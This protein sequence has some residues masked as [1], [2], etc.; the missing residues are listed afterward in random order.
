MPNK[1]LPNA[2]HG[3]T[4]RMMKSHLENLCGY[5]R[6]LRENTVTG[7]LFNSPGHS[8][9]ERRIIALEQSK[10]KNP[11]YKNKGRHTILIYLTHI[12]KASTDK[13]KRRGRGG[14][15]ISVLYY[16]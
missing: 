10:K 15:S 6:N 8:L 13:A 16:S 7:F 9:S 12:T 4:K 11:F 2:I 1:Y 14:Y 3:A 5:E